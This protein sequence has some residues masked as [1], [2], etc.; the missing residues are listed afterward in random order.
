MAIYTG[1]ESSVWFDALINYITG[2]GYPE[3]NGDYSKYWPADLHVVGKDI[4]RFHCIIWPAMLLAADLPLPRTVFGHGF[5]YHSGTKMSKSLGNIV[6][7]L[8][9]VERTGADA[10]RYFLL[11]E[12]IWGQDGD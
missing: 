5:I 1:P 6:N 4:T 12:I 7:P 11:R 8:D 3:R 9:V 10:L 2:V